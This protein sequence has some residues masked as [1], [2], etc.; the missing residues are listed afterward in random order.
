LKIIRANDCLTTPWKNGGGS[1]TEIAAEPA[2]AS[3][4]TFDWRISMA[5][6]ASDGPFSEFFGIDRTLAVIKGSGLV[7]TIGNNASITLDRGSD[8]TS[9]SGDIATSAQLVAGKITDLNVMT[10]RGR[11]S[12]RLRRIREPAWFD[13]DSHDSAVV[14]SLDGST[15][16]T[17]ERDT[18]ILG[19]ADAAILVQMREVSFRITPTAASNCYLILLRE[20]RSA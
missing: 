11:F 10:R 7:L 12:H 5:Q 4:D 13:F 3:L 19:H 20:H 17:S 1:T 2:G 16:L 14:L 18:A 15:T 6:V 9:F 8:P